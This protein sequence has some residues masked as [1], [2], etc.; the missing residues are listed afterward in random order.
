MHN[1]GPAF[2]RAETARSSDIDKREYAIEGTNGVSIRDYF[3][4]AA[5]TGI[6]AN[7]QQLQNMDA[8]NETP[9]ARAYE[10][11][12]DMLAAREANDEH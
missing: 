2:P 10:I 6:L 8:F 3:A 9:A 1:G 5:L 11:A 12:D 7:Q 4:A